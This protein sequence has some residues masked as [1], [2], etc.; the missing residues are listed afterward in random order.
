MA[1]RDETLVALTGIF[2]NV[3]KQ[4][5]PRRE[6]SFKGQVALNGS[7]LTPVKL[8]GKDSAEKRALEQEMNALLARVNFLESRAVNSA[9]NLPI[10]PGEPLQSPTYP[11][12]AARS[13]SATPDRRRSVGPK[14]ASAKY[15]SNWLAEDAQEQ[16]ASSAAPTAEELGYIRDHV[17]RQAQQIETQREQLDL[18]STEI[19]RQKRDQD[20][21]FGH[22]IEDIGALKREL[23]KHQQANLAFQKALREI[24]SIITAVANG[25]LRK[26]VL[27]HAK[28]LDPEIATFK[29]TTNKMVD[30]LSEFASQVT[31]LARE[32]GTEGRLGGQAVVPDVK[33]VWAELTNNGTSSSEGVLISS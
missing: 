23:A 30:Q 10:T 6:Q 8:P 25:D 3:A 17:G 5:D 20:D 21:I 15:L 13:A 11:S 24:G 2:S 14:D 4:W 26:K 29:R 16:S 27:I 1:A 7:R 28:E 18:L 32:V 12:E 33:G 19:R 31:R 9:G 22:G